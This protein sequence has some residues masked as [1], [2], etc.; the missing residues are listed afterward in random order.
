MT[1]PNLN[2]HLDSSSQNSTPALIQ[3]KNG[4]T[5]PNSTSFFGRKIVCILA[6]WNVG[7][8]L[9]INQ[10]FYYA[11]GY[12]RS[13][14][15]AL[16]IPSLKDDKGV[17]VKRTTHTPQANLDNVLD[18]LLL[19]KYVFSK[20][21]SLGIEHLH[22]FLNQEK[23]ENRQ[24]IILWSF[25][26]RKFLSR[27]SHVDTNVVPKNSKLL[28]PN[29]KK[30]MLNPDPLII[31][32]Q[33]YALSLSEHGVDSAIFLTDE[34][35]IKVHECQSYALKHKGQLYVGYYE[36]GKCIIQ[37]PAVRACV[38][39]ALAMIL[40]DQKINFDFEI[41]FETN[42]A[43]NNNIVHWLKPYEYE[44]IPLT[45]DVK[46]ISNWIAE[47]GSLLASIHAQ[48]IGSHMIVVDSI[49][50][51][52]VTIRDPFHGWRITIKTKLF[53]DTMSPRFLGI[54]KIQSQMK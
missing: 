50:N 28:N 36:D 2:L 51:D 9:L 53:L 21:G 48:K 11:A 15:Q 32:E 38:P 33:G 3:N 41:L 30:S 6:V 54:R 43:D 52:Q 35:I 1:S 45:S 34:E 17:S 37:Q 10:I 7:L 14:S 12:F 31:D 24:K 26:Q 16:T 23:P 5:G 13:E 25:S 20:G 8:Y 29:E 46:T 44:M 42:L 18:K 19:P 40:E 39:T 27:G 4:S 22:Y 47:N 49:N